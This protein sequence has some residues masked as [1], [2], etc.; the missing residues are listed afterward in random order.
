MPGKSK[1]APKNK[2]PH[3]N[4]FAG[5]GGPKGRR[6]PPHGAGNPGPN[7][8]WTDPKTRERI[9]GKMEGST[10]FDDRPPRRKQQFIAMKARPNKRVEPKPP[11]EAEPQ[12]ASK[13]A[14]KPAVTPGG[15]KAEDDWDQLNLNLTV[16]GGLEAWKALPE[17]EQFRIAKIRCIVLVKDGQTHNYWD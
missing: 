7:K 5:Q 17:N 14:P 11:T 10:A 15:W 13:A 16:A 1:E 3:T 9:R 12:P 8:P 4:R 6:T 2:K